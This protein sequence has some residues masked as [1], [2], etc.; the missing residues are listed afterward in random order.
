MSDQGTIKL[1]TGPRAGQTVSK[2]G[3]KDAS[4]TGH[5]Q[6][7]IDGI[8]GLIENHAKGGAPGGT[9]NGK[10]TSTDSAVDQMSQAIKET[11]GNSTD[12]G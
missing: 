3:D 7:I 11:P 9:I 4:A 1:G 8:K 2:S 10:A 12:Y 5:E 6:S